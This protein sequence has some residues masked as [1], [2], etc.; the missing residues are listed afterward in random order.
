V[1][2]FVQGTK[3][4][5]QFIAQFRL[6]EIRERAKV[7][8]IAI[9]REAA[10]GRELILGR[11][12]HDGGHPKTETLPGGAA[13][14]ADREVRLQQQI[15]EMRSSRKYPGAAAA[16]RHHFERGAMRVVGADHHIHGQSGERGF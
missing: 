3:Q 14:G 10:A 6:G 1:P 16:R 11:A 9:L 2:A 5:L 12:D 15:G 13:A 7:N 4:S 8:D